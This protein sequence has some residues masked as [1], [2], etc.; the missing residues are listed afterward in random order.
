MVAE[1]RFYLRVSTPFLPVLVAEMH[2]LFAPTNGCGVK[3]INSLAFYIHSLY[4]GTGGSLWHTRNCSEEAR[5]QS[6]SFSTFIPLARRP[7]PCNTCPKTQDRD[8]SLIAD[9]ILL[10]ILSISLAP[11][12]LAVAVVSALNPY[13][14]TI[15]P[16]SSRTAPL[17]FPSV[18]SCPRRLEALEPGQHHITT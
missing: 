4:V 1:R 17:L 3:S 15:C 18:E 2:Q 9:F 12:P 6:T 10:G 5:K 16:G 8:E 7:Y 14:S 11:Y 13:I